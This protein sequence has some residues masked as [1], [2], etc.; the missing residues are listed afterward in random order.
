MD[1]NAAL[2]SILRGH[3][4]YDHVDALRGWLASRGFEPEPT[5]MPVDCHEAFGEWSKDHDVTADSH[6]IHGAL[7][8]G[9]SV[10]L[11]WHELSELENSEY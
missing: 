10:T 5:L 4:I 6:G 8:S 2:E 9:E 3:M 7:V 1:P 11:E